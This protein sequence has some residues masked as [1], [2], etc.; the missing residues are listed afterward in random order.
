MR[1]VIL[2][3]PPPEVEALIESRHT[4]GADRHDEV[5]NGDLHMNPAPRGRHSRLQTKLTLLL[6]PLAVRAGLFLYHEV[7]LGEPGDYRIPDLALLRD[8]TDATRYATAAVV[9][10]IV[11]PHD[12][13]REKLPFYAARGVEE[14]VVVDP[15]ART[16]DWLRATGEGFVTVEHSALLEVDVAGFT[17]SIDWPPVAEPE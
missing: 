5:W 3:Q 8:E 13:T 4:W 14:A 16:V 2:G 15:V 6:D 10:E 9:V 1:T 7:N 12:E 11:S 17:R